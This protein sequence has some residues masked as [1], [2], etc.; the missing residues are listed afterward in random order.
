VGIKEAAVRSVPAQ[1]SASVAYNIDTHMT[2]RALIYE[3]PVPWCNINWGVRGEHLDDPAKV[4][5]LVLERSLIGDP[6]DQALLS[7][8]LSGEFAIVSQVS[9]QDQ[10]VLVAKRIRPP[11]HPLGV[12]PPP[13]ECYAR[14]ALDRFQP[15]L[16][17]GG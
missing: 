6:R 7:D 4:Q 10:D 1:A 13:G 5:Y 14:P 12:A 11:A 16:R 8:L 17:S 15:D 2:H 3:F 9:T